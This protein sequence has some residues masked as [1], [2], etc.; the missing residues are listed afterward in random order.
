[1]NCTKCGKVATSE[2]PEP[3]C[4]EHWAEWWATNADHSKYEHNKNLVLEA[5]QSYQKTP[6][7]KEFSWGARSWPMWANTNVMS[8]VTNAFMLASEA[9]AGQVRKYTNLPYITHPVRVAMAVASHPEATHNMI[10]AALLHDTLED[11]A[12]KPE[13]IEDDCGIHVLD[14]VR[15]LTNPSKGMGDP[16]SV[17][18]Q[19]DRDHLESADRKIKIIKML[20]RID[21]LREMTG[22]P[23]GFRR[24]YVEE[25]MELL[26]VVAVADKDVA[27]QLFDAIVSL[28]SQK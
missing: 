10:A 11:T 25:S 8:V 22:A 15:A 23:S 7:E 17:R 13:R 28:E 26:K 9:H 16:R 4:T 3:L 2:S 27:Y 1:M 5:I 6:Q 20:D 18:K 12:L 21:N 14:Y 19:R 24:L